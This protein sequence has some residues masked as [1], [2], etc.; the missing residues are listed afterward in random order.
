MRQ[1]NGKNQLLIFLT[2]F[3]QLNL[4]LHLNQGEEELIAPSM[5]MESGDGLE[6]NFQL[7]KIKLNFLNPCWKVTI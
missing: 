1:I 3:F 5:M 2:I 6:F 7:K 4:E